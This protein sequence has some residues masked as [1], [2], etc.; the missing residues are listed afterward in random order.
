MLH[1]NEGIGFTPEL[2]KH[3]SKGIIILKAIEA[4]YI[5]KIDAF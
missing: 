5:S 2:I 3:I 1:I 4:T